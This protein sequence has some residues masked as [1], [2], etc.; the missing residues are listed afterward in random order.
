MGKWITEQQ[1]IGCH[2]QLKQLFQCTKIMNYDKEFKLLW[3]K[4]NKDYNTFLKNF[5]R[6]VNYGLTDAFDEIIKG[7][8]NNVLGLSYDNDHDDSWSHHHERNYWIVSR[9]TTIESQKIA[10]IISVLSEFDSEQFC[11]EYKKLFKEDC[12]PMFLQLSTYG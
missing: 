5:S 10:D 2:I 9:Q 1:E 7:L 6:E 8:T 11:E 12:E 4:H 3:K